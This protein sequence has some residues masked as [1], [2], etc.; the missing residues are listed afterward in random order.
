MGCVLALWC[1]VRL[2]LA[3]FRISSRATTTTQELVGTLHSCMEEMYGHCDELLA[4]CHKDKDIGQLQNAVQELKEGAG[5]FLQ[6]AAVRGV[7]DGKI[8]NSDVVV[9]GATMKL[10]L[11]TVSAACSRA[12]VAAEMASRTGVRGAV[13][14]EDDELL[15]VLDGVRAAIA[16]VKAQIQALEDD[17][18]M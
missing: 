6:Q 9:F 17:T 3:S 13:S 4:L 18:L 12:V 7:G 1:F 8:E 10:L 14:V 11:A 5:T 2:L 15:H 16:D